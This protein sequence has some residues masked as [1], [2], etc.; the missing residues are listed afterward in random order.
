MT[1]DVNVL[2]AASRSDH[3]HHAVARDWLEGAIG[4]SRTGASL[5]LMPMV[6]ASFLRLVTSPKIFQQATPS[7]DAIAFIDAILA[8]PGVHLAPLGP[9]WSTLRQLC[10]DTQLTGNNLPDAWL[11]AAV[12]HRAEHLV[13][14]DRDFRK[15]LTRS[16]FTLLAPA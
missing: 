12:T 1:P 11:S 3:P 8:S 9:E 4:A 10:L 15:L 6:L 2:V 7:K 16:Q 13:T 5:T 14:F